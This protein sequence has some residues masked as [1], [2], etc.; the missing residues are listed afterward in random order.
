MLC[1]CHAEVACTLNWIKRGTVLV[2]S[3]KESFEGHALVW[4]FQDSVNSPRFGLSCFYPAPSKKHRWEWSYLRSSWAAV[5]KRWYPSW[6]FI[7]YLP[8]DVNDSPGGLV[9]VAPVQAG[10]SLQTAAWLSPGSPRVASGAASAHFHHPV[11]DEWIMKGLFLF[12]V[13]CLIN[14][15]LQSHRRTLPVEWDAGN[16]GRRLRTVV[17]HSTLIPFYFMLLPEKL[18]LRSR[19]VGSPG[20]HWGSLRLWIHRDNLAGLSCS[21]PRLHLQPNT[22]SRWDRHSNTHLYRWANI[23]FP[24]A[25]IFSFFF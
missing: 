12:L 8:C 22:L 14:I 17:Q 18:P 9:S 6:G 21:L 7:T 11:H 1:M 4:F 20:L 13:A 10:V 23:G 15:K 3:P 5:K 2:I 24:N 19:I 16:D 25:N